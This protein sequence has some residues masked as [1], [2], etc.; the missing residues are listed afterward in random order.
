M[1]PRLQARLVFIVAPAGAGKSTLIS[2]LEPT[3]GRTSVVS[4]ATAH[5][6]PDRLQSAI[7]DAAADGAETVAVDD[8]GCVAG[9]PAER[10]LERMAGSAWRMPRL[11]LA[12]RLPLPSSVV[13]AA[14][15]RSTTITAPELGLRIDEISSLFAEVAGS[16]LGLRC[17]SRVAQETAGWPVLVELLARRARRV[18]PDAVESMVESD[19]ASDFAAGC[20]ETALE[21]LPRDLRRA[22]ERT[23][24]LPRLDFAACA[25]VLGA[26]GAGRLLGAFDSGSVMH[27]VVLGHRVVPPVLRRHLG[28]CRT[29]A[30]RP[31]GPSAANRRPAMSPTPADPAH[32]P[33]RPPAL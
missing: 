28:E 30:G 7:E 6:D 27:E 33:E 21:A 13:H 18:D 26:S 2:R 31:A 23:S 22:L 20:L 8:I 9:T 14:A 19:L 10:T 29:L 16:P 5:R 11:V 3:L 32:A 25:R 17:A 24:E 1:V 12:S 4:A 15:E